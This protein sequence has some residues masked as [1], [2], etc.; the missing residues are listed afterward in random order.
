MTFLGMGRLGFQVAGAG[1]GSGRITNVGT[2]AGA[3]GA[4]GASLAASICC[5]GP[6]A[7]TL[8]GVQGA[9]LAAGIKPY[10]PILLS[11]SAVLL[12]LA[13]WSLHRPIFGGVS[14]GVAA[15][16]FRKKLVWASTGLWVVA[17][18]IQFFAD[19]FWL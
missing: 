11:V 8:L 3:A 6:I 13:H 16:G 2:A 1:M 5:I 4:A 17:L 19:R 12:L 15:G 18:F 9:I 7:I 10:R 14:C